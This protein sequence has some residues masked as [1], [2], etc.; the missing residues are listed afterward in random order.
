MQRLTAKVL[1]ILLLAAGTA[2]AQDFH[3][4]GFSMYNL[5]S[6]GSGA[7]A[8]A[9]GGAFLGVSDD[10][11]ALTWTPAG[12]I[13]IAK[14]QASVSGSVIRIQT[15]NDYN[16][17]ELPSRNFLGDY[18]KDLLNLA[19]GSFVS[20]IRIKGHP[21]V[22]A[23]SYQRAIDDADASY[24][25]NNVEWEHESSTYNFTEVSD[26]SS[27]TTYLRN[28]HKFSLGFGTGIYGNLSFGGGANIYYGSGEANYTA[29]INDTIPRVVAGQTIDSSQVHRIM[30]V[31]DL[32]SVSSAGL[33]GSF[34]YRTPKVRV[35]VTVHSPFE[36][37]TDH[38][39]KKA[40]TTYIKSIRVPGQGT[41]DGLTRPTLYRGKT[42]IEVPMTLG[43]GASIQVTPKFLVSGDVEMR[44]SSN[45]KYFVR[46]EN[47]VDADLFGN[48]V[49]TLPTSVYYDDSSETSYFDASGDLVEIYGEYELHYESTMQMRFGAEYMLTTGLG[50]IPLRGGVRFTQLPYRSVSNVSRDANGQV[51]NTFQL[52]DRVTR[53]SFAFGSGIHWTQIWLDLSVELN[54]E[55]QDETGYELTDF[56]NSTSVDYSNTRTKKEPAVNLTFTGFF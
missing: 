48:N 14:T 41:P 42:K 13:Q 44:S 11:S 9:M 21:F 31:E 19:A 3:L 2:L 35:A 16:Y 38:D 10:A 7:R 5:E 23:G 17:A 36:L 56:V 8:R 34:M 24:S 43:L 20:P 25:R 26:M 39:I 51:Q 29:S 33:V 46:R 55:S 15:E 37:V 50:T 49:F 30:R 12:L 32:Q 47:Q 52:G 45:S 40:D 22:A 1:L 18:T 6:L 28:L 54:K 53:T 27:E 4:Y